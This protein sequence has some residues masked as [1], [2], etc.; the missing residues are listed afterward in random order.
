M[1]ESVNQWTDYANE[2]ENYE[3]LTVSGATFLLQ[4]CFFYVML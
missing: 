3:L 2:F 4:F 1:D